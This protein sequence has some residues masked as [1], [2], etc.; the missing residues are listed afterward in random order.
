MIQID[1]RNVFAFFLL[2]IIRFSVC[3]ILLNQKTD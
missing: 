2:A 1:H 3:Y